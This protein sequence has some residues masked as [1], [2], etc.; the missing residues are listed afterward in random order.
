[1]TGFF[2]SFEGIEGS[3]KST[4][5]ALLADA[6]RAQGHEVVLTRE[7][8]G[9]P[10]GQVLRRLLL[11]ASASPLAPGA[12]LFLLLADRSQHVQ[13]VIAPALHAGKIVLSD[14]F[15]DSTTAYQ[16]FAR[17]F[18]AD[19]L[20]Q[21]NTFA[22]SGCIPALTFVMDLEVTEG[23][24]RARQRQSV[25]TDR[26]EAESIAFHERVR[27]GFLEIARAE[28]QRVQILDATRPVEVNHQEIL[29]TVR[30]RLVG[31]NLLMRKT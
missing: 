31:K 2:I 30:E 18:K 23:L 19:F 12:E 17:G 29:A 20:S 22:C 1:M 8:G 28:S 13:E 16:G 7:P 15:L 24:R 11:E 10:V 4:Q 3:G 21:L 5:I 6:L 14:R 26:F 25:A 9:T 27:S